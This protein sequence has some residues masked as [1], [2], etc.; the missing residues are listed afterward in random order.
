MRHLWLAL[1]VVWLGAAVSA[2]RITLAAQGLQH[3]VR[4]TCRVELV[5]E[6]EE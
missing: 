5:G 2:D 3:Y 6:T 1:G 4:E